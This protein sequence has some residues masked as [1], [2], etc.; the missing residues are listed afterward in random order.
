MKRTITLRVRL[1]LFLSLIVQA[2]ILNGN[3]VAGQFGFVYA[4]QQVNG[5]TNQ[6]YG[7][8]FD[9]GTGTLTLLPGFPVGSGGTGT[10]ASASEQLVYADGRLY[11][12]NNGSDNMTAFSV[13]RSTGALTAMPFNPV[14]LGAGNW[15]CVAVHPGGSP[16]VVGNG[17]GGLASFIVTNISANPAAGSPFATGANSFSCRFSQNGLYVY[18][19]GNGGSTIAGFSVNSGTGVLTALAGSPFDTGATNSLGYATDTSG[20][21]FS[22]SLNAPE[23]RAFTTAS[24]VPSGASGNPFASGLTSGIHGVLHPGGFYMV[25]D[26]GDNRVGSYEISGTAAAT[27]LTAVAGSPF[28]TGGTFT[29]VLAVTANGAHLLAANGSTRNLTVFQVNQDTGV[30]SSIGV[31]PANTLGASGVITG[32]VFAESEAGFV[33][34]LQQLDGALN[35]IHGFRINPSTGALIALAG[36]PISSGG[37]GSSSFPSEQIAYANGRLFVLN[38]GSNTLSAF[39]VN[40]TTGALTPLAFSPVALGPGGWACVAV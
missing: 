31:Q 40:R 18:T 27:T 35:Q 13:N 28:P 17:S 33:Y 37:N 2:S 30:L 36:F 1:I 14:N 20:R 6:I 5:G 38:D 3:A 22:V 10:A 9:S 11:V 15:N 19:G 16:V 4:L 29:H 12:L 21:L 26:R 34:T 7:F 23:L 25:A 24:G 39:K 32:L 8:R